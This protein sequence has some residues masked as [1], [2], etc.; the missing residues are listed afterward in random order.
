M[1]H[2]LQTIKENNLVKRGETVAVACSG[3]SD[4]MA[5]LHK[6]KSLENELDIEVIAVSVNHSIRETAERDVKFVQDFC[7]RNG[8]R[9]YKFK[10]DVPKLAKAK[11]ISLESAGREARYGIFDAL[12]QKG[13]A[14]K[15]AL[16]HHLNDQAETILLHLFRGAGLSGMKGMDYQKDGT[17]IRPMLSTPKEEVLKYLSE[18]NI[19]YVEDE[20]NAESTY[21]RNFLRNEVFPLLLKK[22]PNIV[23]TLNN[24]SKSACEDDEYIKK[25]LNDYA[26]LIEDKV[27]KIPLSYFSYDE[28][29][30][31]RIIFKAL[32]GIG[33][34]VDIE[35]KHVEMVKDLA[36]NAENGKKIDLPLGVS[37]FK[38]YEYLTL[39]NKK[40]EIIRFYAELKCGEVDVPTYGKLSIK[41][42]K[43]FIPKQNVLYVDYKKV[44]RDAVW[45]FRQNGD[46][47]EKFGGCTKKLKDYFI[48][49][50]IPQRERDNIPVL[51]SGNEILVIAGMEISEK[52][53]IEDDI[54]T[55]L[56]IEAILL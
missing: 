23:N 26:L 21:T 34:G 13:V 2:I 48:D 30:I 35:R 7:D 46:V 45:R 36:R 22:W 9:F 8:I 5:L 29:V 32:H 25:N 56:K 43:D 37:A 41:R 47:F 51:A 4:S 24:F 44:P 50:K 19:E 31:N 28:P 1:D 40:K 33:I 18:N 42:V 12:I 52:V 10:V 16:A 39:T 55:A 6:L 14:N 53:K 3:G 15:I 54:K 27:A 11:A 38:E 17:Y 49:K 20:T